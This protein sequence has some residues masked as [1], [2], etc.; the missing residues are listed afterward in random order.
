VTVT[1]KGPG[2][3]ED[4]ST[5][6]ID[7][8]GCPDCPPLNDKPTANVDGCKDGK[9]EVTFQPPQTASGVNSLEWD[10]G[11]GTTTN[12]QPGQSVTHRY[13]SGG[14]YTVTVTAKGPDDCEDSSTTKIEIKG[15]PG[16]K[17]GNGGGSFACGIAR[18]GTAVLAAM[19]IFTALLALC[20]PGAAQALGIAAGVLAVGAVVLGA[21]F[22]VLC[23][24]KPCKWALL[25]T[26]QAALG[27]G[28]GA[29]IFSNCCSWLLWAGLG[30]M[31]LGLVLFV[32]WKRECNK[33][34]C[35]VAKEVTYV[36]SGIVLT[37]VGIASSIPVIT[38]CINGTVLAVVSAIAGLIA[39]YAAS[40]TS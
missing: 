5:T 36:I 13:A 35:A 25:M 32:V 37:L 16:D 26:A 22:A 29:A 24:N 4:S 3:C 8:K 14:E 31:I 11:D 33:S 12:S 27:A 1:A 40:C 17:N 15:C 28:V 6:K 21:V 7:I 10:F 9:R 20:I 39:A 18:V 2:D 19:T 38:G 30:L 34:W 23:D